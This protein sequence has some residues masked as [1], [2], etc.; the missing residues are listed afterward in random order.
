[1]VAVRLSQN[2]RYAEFVF[3]MCILL[4]LFVAVKPHTL[5]ENLGHFLALFLPTTLGT[6]EEKS[7]HFSSRLWQQ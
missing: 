2:H 1:M 5:K 3:F 4:L 6:F 7:G